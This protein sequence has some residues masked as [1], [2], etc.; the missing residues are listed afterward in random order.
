M[1]HVASL[2]AIKQPMASEWRSWGLKQWAEG[3]LEAFFVD[4]AHGQG[5]ITQLVITPDRLAH[6]VD[7]VTVDPADVRAHFLELFRRSVRPEYGAR[8]QTIGGHARDLARGWSSQS[9][10]TPP[11]LPHLILTCLAATDL[12]GEN[13]NFRHHLNQMLVIDGA[14][15]G[16]EFISDLWRDFFRWLERQRAAGRNLRLVCEP[17]IGGLTQIGYPV[18]LAFP[19]RRDQRLL[20]RL[21]ADRDLLGAEPPIDAVRELVVANLRHFTS[22]FCKAFNEFDV[23]LRRGETL[24]RSAFWTAIR[25]ATLQQHIA[26]L[27]GIRPVSFLLCVDPSGAASGRLVLFLMADSD[28]VPL[29]DGFS[30]VASNVP[31][32]D[33]AYLLVDSAEQ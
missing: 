18:R 20:V 12:E 31:L 8:P 17:D 16:L 19:T 10:E 23:Q 15:H 9:G 21:L 2:N 1:L 22:E 33:H 25:E 4:N 28:D 24:M 26:T 32:E 27:D 6:V 7:D 14:N 3:L 5:P 29:P 30:F 11:F 13:N